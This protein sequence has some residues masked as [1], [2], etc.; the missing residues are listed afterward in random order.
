MK[1]SL[2]EVFDPRKLQAEAQ[3]W[4]QEKVSSL[5]GWLNIAQHKMHN[6]PETNYELGVRFAREGKLRDAVFR[7]RLVLKLRPDWADA[8]FELGLVQMRLQENA[9]AVISFKNALRYSPAHADARYLLAVCDPKALAADKQ[10]TTMPLHMVQGFFTDIA[11]QYALQEAQNNYQA[12]KVVV[13]AL[14]PHLPALSGLHVVDAGCGIGH[15]ASLWRKVAALL[16]GIDVTEAMVHYAREG[17]SPDKAQ[18]FDKV[19]V[20]DIRGLRQYVGVHSQ[21]VIL[22][23]NVLQFVGDLDA[24]FAEFAACLKAGGIAAITVEPYSGQHYGVVSATGRFG[25]TSQY[26]AA[27]AAKHGLDVALQQNAQIY[28]KMTCLL[29][30]LKARPIAAPA[31][32]PLQHAPQA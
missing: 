19:H 9:E 11:P 18:L 17:Q 32:S 27:T 12:A 28:P 14:R 31:P 23:V 20:G 3:D 8:W 15:C 2:A 26:I 25:H 22:C 1:R 6:L 29:M 21:D 7:Y 30:V 24:T 16:V 10:P 4:F 13:E 5:Q